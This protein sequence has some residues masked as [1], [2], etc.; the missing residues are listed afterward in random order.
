M[1]TLFVVPIDEGQKLPTERFSL[2]RNHDSA[3]AFVLDGSYHALDHGDTCCLPTAPVGSKYSAGPQLSWFTELAD[4]LRMP[5]SA[6]SPFGRHHPARQLHLHRSE[7]SPALVRHTNGTSLRRKPFNQKSLLTLSQ[8]CCR[9]TQDGPVY[10]VDYLP[11]QG[12][13]PGRDS[14]R[15][16]MNDSIVNRPAFNRLSLS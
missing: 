10:R 3:S 12:H 11:F 5:I 13:R 15:E 16:C 4:M 7:R 8:Q 1:R 14:M 6:V 2:Q 9:P